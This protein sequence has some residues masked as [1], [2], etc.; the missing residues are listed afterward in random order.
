MVRLRCVLSLASM[1]LTVVVVMLVLLMAGVFMA[2]C[3]TEEAVQE[4]SVEGVGEMETVDLDDLL[5]SVPE[6]EPLAPVPAAL[7]TLEPGHAWPEL[8]VWPR[9]EPEVWPRSPDEAAMAF[10]Q[11][12]AR[13]DRVAQPR[14]AIQSGITATAE[15]PRL[16][17]DGTS[18]GVATTIHLQQVQLVDGSLAWV[19]MMALSDDIVVDFPAVGALLAGGTFVLGEGRGFEG[20]I[21]FQLEDQLGQLGFAFAQGGALGENLPFK[22]HLL[23]AQR[24]ASGLWATLI[25]STQSAVDGSL[26]ALTM[27]PMRLVDGS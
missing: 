20:T 15:L 19:V 13:G 17:E 26:L 23:F 6:T 10:A 9:F 12:I 22:T 21:L 24:P 5:I 8:L 27:L 2:A 25:G 4:P 16:A 7:G 3:G 11:H 1:V 18:F 14:P